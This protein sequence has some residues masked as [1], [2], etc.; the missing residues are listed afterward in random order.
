[1]D[2]AGPGWTKELLFT[3]RFVGA[4]EAHRLGLVNRIVP[5]EE[6]EG[7]VRELALEI[8]SNAPLTLLATKEMIRRLMV[9]RRLAAGADRDLIEMCYSSADFR[10]GVAAFLAKRK[11]QWRGQ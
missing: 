5:V 11:P 9:K 3:G 7:V 6:I 4:A 1:V 2:L 10:E 8:A